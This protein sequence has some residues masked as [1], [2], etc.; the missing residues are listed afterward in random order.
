MKIQKGKQGRK[1]KYDYHMYR[2]LQTTPTLNITSNLIFIL[3]KELE[4]SNVNSA[5]V[6]LT[7][8]TI[9]SLKN[10]GL[11]L[12]DHINSSNTDIT[13]IMETCQKNKEND[14]AW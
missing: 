2:K 6:R 12:N 7:I 14:T 13:V 8:T 3:V 4:Q 9:Q 5:Q 1:C 11:L 10:K